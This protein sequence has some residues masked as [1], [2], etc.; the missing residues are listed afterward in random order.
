MNVSCARSS[1]S[2]RS[3]TMRKTS[4]NTGRSYR[5]M[6]SRYAASR[7]CWAS[8][9]TSASGRLG[10]SRAGGIE[11]RARAAAEHAA[12]GVVGE[13]MHRGSHEPARSLAGAGLARR[14]FA[15][16]RESTWKRAEAEAAA[17]WRRREARLCAADL[18]GDRAALRSAQSRAQ[19]QHRPALAAACD[20]GA[21]LGRAGPT[22]RYLDLCAGTLDVAAQLARSPGF[23][24]TVIGADFAEP[25]LRAG[26]GKSPAG[27]VRPV[28][29]DALGL[30]F[31]PASM[32][33]AI[34]AFGIR[35]VADL[36]AGLARGAAR[37]R[38]R[39]P[40]RDP[41]VL[42]AALSVRARRLS[43]VLPSRAALRGRGGERP[44]DGVSI[45]AAVGGQLS[46]RSKRSATRMR[47]RRVHGRAV[48]VIDLRHR[49]AARGRRRAATRSVPT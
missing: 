15:D 40:V 10:R 30:P 24:G 11:R 41:R 44:P 14:S 21:R 32:A 42:H 28:V 37:A 43:C 4:E 5:R 3:R 38:A 17:A 49:G 20:R 46:R 36:D 47:T 33:G 29:A 25:M 35:N 12:R 13:P 9:T 6:S 7:P 31:A 27:V 1:A 18:L 26:A 45:P 34:V 39:R 16:A 2:S 19:L 8:A 23:R 22:G 48:A